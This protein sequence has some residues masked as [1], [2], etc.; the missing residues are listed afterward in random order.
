M[1]IK[2]KK[3]FMAAWDKYFPGRELPIICY[4][5]K[6]LGDVKFPNRPKQNNSVR[7]CVKPNVFTFSA[8][9]PKFLRML[10]NMD[11]SFLAANCWTN[12]KSRF[13]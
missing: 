5:T 2:I 8:P 9:W 4:Y 3:R 6:E 12:V 13:K 11:D 7:A 10:E 1:N